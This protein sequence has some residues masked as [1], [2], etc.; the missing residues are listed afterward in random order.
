MI[1]QNAICS[2]KSNQKTDSEKT[3]WKN[4]NKS[5]NANFDR[6]DFY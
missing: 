5:N 4:K 3:N 1:S 2:W 6:L